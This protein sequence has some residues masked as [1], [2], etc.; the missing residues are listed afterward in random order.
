MHVNLYRHYRP[1]S[2][3]PSKWHFAG[4]PIVARGW[5]LTGHLSRGLW[6]QEKKFIE[7]NLELEIYVLAYP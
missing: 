6:F 5:M 2:K 4:W 1:A 3:T 7:V